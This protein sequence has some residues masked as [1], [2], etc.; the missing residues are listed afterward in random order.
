MNLLADRAAR[1][2]ER[3]ALVDGDERW[4]WSRLH[5]EARALAAELQQ[6]HGVAPGDIV[7]TALENDAGHVILLHAIF[8]CGAI[9]AP[10]NVRLTAAEQS[11]QI[12]HLQ[13]RLFLSEPVSFTASSADF[14]PVQTDESRLCSILFTSGTSGEM[15]A[16]PHTWMNHRASAEG[17]AENLGVRTDDNWMCVIP[18]YHIGGLAIVTRS[19]FYGTALTVWKGFEASAILETLG[20]ERITLLS[21]VP[22]MLQ[23]ML[24]ANASFTAASLPALRA[25]LLGGAAASRTLWDDALARGLPVLGTYGLTETCSQVVTASP[26]ALAAMAGSAGRPIGGAELRIEDEH[27]NALTSG[28]TGEI[29]IRGTMVATGYLRNV[30]LTAERFANG[31]FHSGDVGMIDD[32][33]CLHVIGRRDDMIVTGGENVYPTEIEDI[34]VRHPAVHE[35]AVTGVEDADWGQKIAAAIVCHADLTV[36]ELEDWCR[37]EMAGYKIPRVWLRVE[38]LPRTASGKLIRGEVRRMFIDSLPSRP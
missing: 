5:D 12:A 29:C 24:E 15:K 34:L 6:T 22:T 9:A 11:R 31:W 8:L 17:S 32:A 3:I 26:S 14:H 36:A 20:R 21:L 4:N 2:P 33:N 7:A 28:N 27:G 16:V 25:I 23:R 35:T 38:V 18:L 30:P 19:L 37:R 1:W 13:P 10:L